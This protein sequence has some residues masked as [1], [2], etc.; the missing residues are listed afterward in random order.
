ML[1]YEEK[2]HFDEHY[3]KLQSNRFLLVSLGL[4]R[5]ILGYVFLYLLIK[6]IF[7]YLPD[8]QPWDSANAWFTLCGIRFV[9][10]DSAYFLCGLIVSCYGTLRLSKI[11]AQ[12]HSARSKN[13]IR[14]QK[15]LSDGC[16]AKVRHPMY[17]TFIILQAGFM[18]SL[19]SFVGMILALLIIVFQYMNAIIE[20]QKQLK[21]LFGKEYD[22]YSKNVTNIILTKTEFFVLVSTAIL[23]AIGFAF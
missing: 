17:G 15:L 11:T 22:W 10:A 1:K 16:Y 3:S 5:G 4:A 19:R 9:K 18:L 14:P 7:L 23:S 21:P 20:E 13:G 2:L 6:H 12:N 8:L